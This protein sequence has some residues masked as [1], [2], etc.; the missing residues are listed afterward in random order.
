MK[1]NGWD[2]Q[3]Q[4]IQ[5]NDVWMAEQKRTDKKVERVIISEC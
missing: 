2:L 1:T 5:S 3:E 4:H